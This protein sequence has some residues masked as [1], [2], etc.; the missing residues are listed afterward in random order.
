MLASVLLLVM[1]MNKLKY[2]TAIATVLC[3]LTLSA[4][5]DL[6]LSP[7]GDIPKNGTGVNGGNSDNQVN[8]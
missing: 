8:N 5:A 7:F 4:K 2:L 3:A 1:D 6:I